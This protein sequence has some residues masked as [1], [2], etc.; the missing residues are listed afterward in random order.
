MA[1]HFEVALPFDLGFQ[2]PHCLQGGWDEG[3][4]LAMAATGDAER[5]ACI[6]AGG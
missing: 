1:I 5:A 4:I 2:I 3:A 6:A